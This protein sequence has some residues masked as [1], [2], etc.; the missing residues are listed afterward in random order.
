MH[1][2]I[3]L[4]LP[5]AYLHVLVSSQ[6]YKQIRSPITQHAHHV[7]SPDLQMLI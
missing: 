5:S 3:D 2:M 7:N 4:G 6:R 1:N